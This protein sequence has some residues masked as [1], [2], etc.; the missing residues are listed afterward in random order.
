[1]PQEKGD[2]ILLCEASTANVLCHL[3]KRI[4]HL[5]EEFL[6]F[7]SFWE[8]AEVVLK[9]RRKPEDKK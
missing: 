6:L 9:L 8:D 5:T 2:L 3:K 7:I 4:T 1:M